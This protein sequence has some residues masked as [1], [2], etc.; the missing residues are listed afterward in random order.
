[1][2]NR[3]SSLIVVGVRYPNLPQSSRLLVFGKTWDNPNPNLESN[4][5]KHIGFGC[6][7]VVL[8]YYLQGFCTYTI[9]GAMKWSSHTSRVLHGSPWFP[10]IPLPGWLF[11]TFFIH[12]SGR[13][14]ADQP[15]G[16]QRPSVDVMEKLDPAPGMSALTSNPNTTNNILHENQFLEN[17]QVSRRNPCRSRSFPDQMVVEVIFQ[18]TYV[19]VITKTKKRLGQREPRCAWCICL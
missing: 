2:V 15:I 10:W 8:S 3:E 9:P 14:P 6:L 1:M 13:I 18:D 19:Q 16:S 12:A 17:N 4:W 11:F 7:G 5:S